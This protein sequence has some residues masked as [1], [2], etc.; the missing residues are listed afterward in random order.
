MRRNPPP[1]SGTPARRDDSHLMRRLFL[2]LALSLPA[3]HQADAVM[4]PIHYQLQ[5]EASTIKAIA[6]VEKVETLDSGRHYS[7]QK[8]TFRR[9]GDPYHVGVPEHFTGTSH[10]VLHSWQNPVS[11]GDI[12]LYPREGE[13]V[14]VTVAREGEA[15]TSY[16]P[17]NPTLEKVLKETPWRIRYGMRTIHVEEKRPKDDWF[18]LEIKG[19]RAGYL[20]TG[21]RLEGK[22][23]QLLDY[24]LVYKDDGVVQQV[25]INHRLQNDRKLT[26]LQMTLSHMIYVLKEE[27]ALGRSIRE[28]VVE[29]REVPADQVQ[30][31]IL[32][33][34]AG[35]EPNI[36][37]VPPGMMTDLTI[38]EMVTRLPFRKNMP[39]RFHLLKAEELRLK[40]GMILEYRGRDPKEGGLHHF[41]ETTRREASYWLDDHHILIKAAWGHDT[42]FVRTDEGEAT[43]VFQ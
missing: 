24:E 11:G 23:P 16:A 5:A 33:P 38:L 32:T 21:R 2:L 40:K 28:L 6:R 27:Q 17:L 22:R 30:D 41:V 43:T 25:Y 4:P 29:F 31:G 20:H 35:K 13:T 8:T 15:I 10:A 18:I 7:I 42:R 26:P 14:F 36:L 12:Y 19:E 37:K 1:F 34:E 3:A 39:F 9:M